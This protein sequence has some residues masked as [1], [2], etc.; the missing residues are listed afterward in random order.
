[1]QIAE[2]IEDVGGYINAYTSRETT[3]Y[4]A[5]VL[6]ADTGLALDVIADILL[7]PAFA[8]EEIEVERGVILQEIGQALD[9]PDDIVFDW[10]QEAAF[11]DQPLGRTIL[12]EAA[13]IGAYGRG[14]LTG[15]VAEHYGPGQMILCAAGGIDHEAVRASAG[16]DADAAGGARAMEERRA[17]G[18]QGSRAGAFRA[19]NRGAGLP[20]RGHSYRAGLVDGA[21][22]GDVVAALSGGAREARAVLFDLCADRGL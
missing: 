8:P 7:N 6:A 16:A 12:G 17:A 22:R 18:D 2:A 1:L 13:A 14:D 20:Q 4:Y 19:G 21:G 15:F 9:T 10:L 3:A 11:P 5:R